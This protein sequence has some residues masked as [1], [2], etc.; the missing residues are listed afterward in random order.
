MLYTDYLGR[1][2][3]LEEMTTMHEAIRWLKQQGI[4]DNQI[5]L[6]SFVSLDRE[7]KQITFTTEKR[8]VILKKIVAYADSP[9]EVQIN[10]A[11]ENL[12]SRLFIF[13]RRA[14]KTKHLFYAPAF[15][16]E[17]FRIFTGSKPPKAKKTEPLG[18]KRKPVIY[19]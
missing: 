17:E 13:P 4:K 3:T 10:E 9:L 5:R 14:G 18:S 8:F 19:L 15:N 12:H 11:R 2:L 16:K 1:D 7:N 6:L